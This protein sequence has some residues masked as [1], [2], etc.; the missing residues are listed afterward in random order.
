MNV[1]SVYEEVLIFTRNVKLYSNISNELKKLGLKEFSMYCI[2][3][4]ADFSGLDILILGTIGN[5][6]ISHSN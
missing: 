6:F 4:Q 2:K 5:P 3:D 1:G